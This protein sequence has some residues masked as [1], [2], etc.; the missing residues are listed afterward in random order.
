ML[1]RLKAPGFQKKPGEA[2]ASGMPL[3]M[4]RTEVALK[5]P[6]ASSVPDATLPGMTGSQSP[7]S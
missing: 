5:S 4:A 6:T 7:Q 2:L 1:G 3:I